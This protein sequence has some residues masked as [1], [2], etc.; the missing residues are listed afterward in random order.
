M[1]GVANDEPNILFL[2]KCNRSLDVLGPCDVHGISDIVAEFAGSGLRLKGVAA[3]IGKEGGHDRRGRVKATMSIVKNHTY[4]SKIFNGVLNLLPRPFL[5]YF[6][7]QGRIVVGIVA[8]R[9]HGDGLDKPA[10]DGLV[11]TCPLGVGWPRLVAGED[12]AVACDRVCFLS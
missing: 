12:F 7:A 10:A 1:A 6:V 2:R 9:A 3:L 11:Q 5:F 4:W 8:R